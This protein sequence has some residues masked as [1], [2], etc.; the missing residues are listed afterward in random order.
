MT[1][2]T[3]PAIF[4]R[5]LVR[6]HIDRAAKDFENHRPLFDDTAAH[7][8]E[9]LDEIK[10]P[11][12][13]ALDLSPFP[14]LAKRPETTVAVETA[15]NPED[16]E[17]PSLAPES[18][19]LIVTNL[20]LHWANDLPGVLAQ[21]RAALRPNGLFLATLIG[22]ESLHELRACLMDAEL[23]E[24]QGASPRV[25]PMIDLKTAGN[26]LRRVGFGL[27]VAD[28]ETVTLL[29]TDLFA[30]MRDLRGM[31]Q[32]NARLDRL[33]RPTRR[34]VF[35]RAATLYRER[36]SNEEGLIHATVDILYLH[37]WR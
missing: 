25:S 22:G 11:F 5:A 12:Q 28:I 10:T 6:R 21:C 14:F 9:R 36:F 33:R 30:L 20:G 37:G 24:T 16:K 35:A 2:E 15:Q 29:Y 1:G 34:A 3:P 26:L 4:D 18:A 31:G 7:L 8:G 17:G 32:A 19:D 27:P 13:K 23:A